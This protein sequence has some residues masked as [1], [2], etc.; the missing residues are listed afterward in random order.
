GGGAVFIDGLD[1]DG[2]DGRALIQF[3]VK[4]GLAVGAVHTVEHNVVIGLG[5]RRE[6]DGT[7]LVVSA[8]IVVANH[9]KEAGVA[10]ISAIVHLDRQ[11]RVV[12]TAVGVESDAAISRRTVAEPIGGS[13]DYSTGVGLIRIFARRRLENLGAAVA[14]DR[15]RCLAA[16]LA[17]EKKQQQQ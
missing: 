17:A 16:S 12:G 10:Q 4:V 8:A 2:R 11:E 9:G 3:V 13:P 15:R 7:G 1:G 5:R 6:F 14:G